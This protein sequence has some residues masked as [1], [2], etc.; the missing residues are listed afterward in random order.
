MK[1]FLS[2]SLILGLGWLLSAQVYI[3]VEPSNEVPSAILQADANDKGIALPHVFLENTNSALPITE[4]PA[5]G[6]IVYNPNLTS[7][8]TPGYYYWTNSPNPHWERIG[9]INEK[10][11]IIQNIDREFL[12]YNPNRMGTDAPTTFTIS[13]STATKQRCVKWNI[14]DG[15]NGHTY[16]SYTTSNGYDFQT[17]F[18]AIKA[19]NGYMVTIVSDAEWDFVLKNVINDGKSIGGNNLTNGIWLGY[20]KFTTPGNSIPKYQWITSESWENTWSNNARVQ[21]N[22]AVGQP[23]ESCTFIQTSNNSSSRLWSSKVCTS[24]TNMTNIIVE[25]NQ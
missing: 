7:D 5:E 23:Q 13:S 18:N 16:C 2:L 21:H 15:G 20:V 3:N 6:L 11:T 17:T 14:T 22:F 4:T 9:G 8:I 24:N 25:F 10:G 19:I 1:N 12:G